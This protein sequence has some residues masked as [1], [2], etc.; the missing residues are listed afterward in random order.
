MSDSQDD[1]YAPG[2]YSSM[3][4]ID[5]LLSAIAGA[6]AIGDSVWVAS[7]AYQLSLLLNKLC[8]IPSAIPL[9]DLAIDGLESL[10]RSDPFLHRDL[11][12]MVYRQAGLDHLL[13]GH[14]YAAAER[15][16]VAMG[17][18]NYETSAEFRA[19]LEWDA[20]VLAQWR[21]DPVEGLKLALS[22]L[23]YYRSCNQPNELYRLRLHIADLA[24]D[25]LTKDSPQGLIKPTLQTPAYLDIVKAQLA[26][27]HP[28]PG[29]G[30]A[31]EIGIIRDLVS[32]RLSRLEDRREDRF[33]LLQ[34][35][36]DLADALRLKHAEGQ[37]LTALGDEL[38][39]IG[40]FEKARQRYRE[41]I[42]L[43]EDSYAPGLALMPR[44][45]LSRLEEFLAVQVPPRSP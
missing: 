34:R 7:L 5:A 32:A 33:A 16:N 6:M 20:S 9:D 8:W 10:P 40:D 38:L 15:F 31:L 24:M 35:V 37:V 30:F 12:L 43:L 1:D 19:A 42:D 41:A 29:T 36:K 3:L 26:E 39:A 28:D 17:L 23:E 21:N 22:A 2:Y 11:R 27:V 25:V 45:R 14:L 4:I 13:L 18:L 44:R